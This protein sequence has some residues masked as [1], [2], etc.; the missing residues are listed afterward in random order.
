MKK[1]IVS[2]AKMGREEIAQLLLN[3]VRRSNLVANTVM[4][5]KGGSKASVFNASDVESCANQTIYKVIVQVE[6]YRAQ[7]Q[8]K[9]TKE[10]RQFEDAP[11]LVKYFETSFGNMLKDMANAADAVKRSRYSEVY[12]TIRDDED[13]IGPEKYGTWEE[14]HLRN[15][16]GLFDDVIN[17]LEVGL[18][19]DHSSQIEIYK[20]ILR[21]MFVER[22]DSEEIIASELSIAEP[23]V[24]RIMQELQTYL[25]LYCKAEMAEIFELVANSVSFWTTGQKE[26]KVANR[27]TSQNSKVSKENDIIAAD[28]N[29]EVTTNT[30]HQKD[31]NGG[32]NT[33]IS[34]QIVRDANGVQEAVQTIKRFQEHSS[35]FEA[36]MQVKRQYSLEIRAAE[37]LAKKVRDARRRE[38]LML[39]G[40]EAA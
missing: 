20:K 21:L 6:N 18:G 7:L 37:Q 40:I 38:A 35:S 1:K 22:V 36:A 24:S 17:K 11:L 32:V 15:L 4:R 39:F 31:P 29:C 2:I 28:M 10:K 12:F 13:N 9:E 25:S 3:Y 8:A 5:N 26:V 30:L 27:I 14:S 23:E 34:V 19:A 16:S 33:T